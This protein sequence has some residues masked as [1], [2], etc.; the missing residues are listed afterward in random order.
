MKNERK[1]HLRVPVNRPGDTPTSESADRHLFQMPGALGLLLMSLCGVAAAQ[2]NG[3]TQ[4]RDFISQQVGGLKNLTVPA[5]DAEIPLP[6]QPDG[7]VNPRYRD[8]RGETLPRK[9]AVP[10]PGSDRAHR[11]QP[12]PAEDLPAGTAFGGTFDA[13]IRSGNH[14]RTGR[15][16]SEYRHCH[17]TDRIVRQLPHRRG[18]GQGGSADQLQRRRRGS[19]LH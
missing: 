12:G 17:E 2:G 15:F 3:P 18:G 16:E 13:T 1:G 9:V 19:R 4:L 5:T 11:H 6:R 7:T 10:R 14:P 8:H